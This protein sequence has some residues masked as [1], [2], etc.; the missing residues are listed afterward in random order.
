MEQSPSGESGQLGS[1]E[2]SRL[3]KQHAVHQQ[4][5]IELTEEQMQAI[6]TQWNEQD[7]RRPAQI[8]FY[9][10]ERAVAELMVAGYRY[11]GNTCCV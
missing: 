11:R 4:I 9:V 3:L 8:T 1:E 2:L 10:S 5:R 6:L 7:P